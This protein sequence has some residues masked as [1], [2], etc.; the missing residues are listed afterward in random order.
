MDLDLGAR[1][2]VLCGEPP[3]RAAR[4]ADRAS[5]PTRR[6]AMS[7]K[8]PPQV[9]LLLNVDGGRRAPEVVDR[10]R[11][12]QHGLGSLAAD[13]G[14]GARARCRDGRRRHGLAA[15]SRHVE[16]SRIRGPDTRGKRS[17][18]LLNDRREACREVGLV[19]LL[20]VHALGARRHEP[21]ALPWE[22]E[23]ERPRDERRLLAGNDLELARERLRE[24]PGFRVGPGLVQGQLRD[25]GV[26][27]EAREDAYAG[28]LCHEA[29]LGSPG[30]LD[31]WRS[32]VLYAEMPI[33]QSGADRLDDG[34]VAEELRPLGVLGR[35]L[36]RLRERGPERDHFGLARTV[37]APVD[38]PGLRHR[39]EPGRLH[40]VVV[41][42]VLGL[43]KRRVRPER[44]K[45][46][47]APDEPDL[48]RHW[49]RTPPS[50]APSWES[51]AWSSRIPRRSSE[52]RRSSSSAR[53][54][55]TA[56]ASSSRCFSAFA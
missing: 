25:L 2:D 46:L 35:V 36:E 16:R 37:E 44:E 48:E 33:A 8:K 9:E 52:R 22:L 27:A 30:P 19:E 21:E 11:F 42:L 53:C 17:A 43:E 40:F 18:R 31:P 10:D 45:G 38:R 34:A 14:L 15:R 54:R 55:A 56:R 4:E 26:G 49:T 41:V 5:P 51:A 12:R 29:E 47:A 1:E 7:P 13:R 3:T 24:E 32:Q 28:D 23:P 6:E 39:D 50:R 20:Y